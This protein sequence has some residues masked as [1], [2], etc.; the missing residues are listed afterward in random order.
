MLKRKGDDLK[1]STMVFTIFCVYV[2]CYLI[3]SILLWAKKDYRASGGYILMICIHVRKFICGDCCRA[4]HHL[5]H[6][7]IAFDYDQSTNLLLHEHEV[8]GCLQES[9]GVQGNG[10]DRFG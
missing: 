1:Y 2:L 5:P 8:Q 7:P 4:L 3:P 6:S 9:E 10:G